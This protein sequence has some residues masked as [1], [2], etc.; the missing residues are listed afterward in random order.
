MIFRVL[1]GEWIE[2]LG[3][4]MRVGRFVKHPFDAAWDEPGG[5]QA[6][7]NEVLAVFFYLIVLVIGNFT[8]LNLFLALL[9][10]N[11]ASFGEEEDEKKKKKEQS[12]KQS[13]QK[14]RRQK[15]SKKGK[16]GAK[17]ISNKGAAPINASDDSNETADETDHEDAPNTPTSPNKRLRK[18]GSSKTKLNQIG[19]AEPTAGDDELSVS[20]HAHHKQQQKGEGGEEE[21]SHPAD[22]VT[23]I[24]NMVALAAA[25]AQEQ[26]KSKDDAGLNSADAEFKWTRLCCSYTIDEYFAPIRRGCW[27]LV[28]GARFSTGIYTRGY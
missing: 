26:E 11:M 22:T 17:E 5:D 27:K 3:D 1:C 28:H 8:I 6:T 13:K 20:S 7:G 19:P 10:N 4:T 21:A 9:I 14:K 25:D 24:G 15:E 18:R 12:K 23:D 16:H 2:P